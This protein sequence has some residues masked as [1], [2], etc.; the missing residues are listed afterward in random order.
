MKREIDQTAEESEAASQELVV[1]V[2]STTGLGLVGG[3]T[4]YALRGGALLASLL[5]TMP[6]WNILD[7]LPILRNSV[8]KKE[9]PDEDKPA[10]EPDKAS[11]KIEGL[12][13]K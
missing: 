1:Q 4:A 13:A 7:P 9:Q 8:K 2:V 12:F 6:V 11:Q 3:A 10:T 5:S